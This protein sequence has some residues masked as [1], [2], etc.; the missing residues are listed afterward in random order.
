[1]NTTRRPR[2]IM[3]TCV[4]FCILFALC[5]AASGKV[6]YVDD[7]AVQANGGTS[8][9]DA[10]TSLQDALAGAAP[11]DEV[12]VAQGTYRPDQGA[13]ITPGDREAAF[14]IPT[15]VIVQGGYPGIHA[16]RGDRDSQLYPTILSGDLKGD[17]SPNP[18]VKTLADDPARKDNSLCV[19]VSQRNTTAT[20][21][22]GF[23]ITGAMRAGLSCVDSNPSISDCVFVYNLSPSEGGAVRLEGSDAV[24][25]QCTFIDNEAG[26]A[27]GAIYCD[28]TH[29]SM[30][31]CTFR[32]NSSKRGGAFVLAG[33][34]RSVMI[35]DCTFILNSADFGGAIHLYSS[36]MTLSGCLLKDNSARLS[37]GAIYDLAQWHTI[38]NCT[39]SSNQGQTGGAFFGLVRTVISNCVFEN[40]SG[41]S[42]SIGSWDCAGPDFVNCTMFGNHA[43]DGSSI[44]I[45]TC[46]IRMTPAV[47][48][49]SCIFWDSGDISATQ[50][51]KTPSWEV[52]YSLIQSGMAG[53]GNIDADPCFAAPGYW[54][55]NATPG[56]PNDDFW[57]DGDYHLKSQ[58]GRW[59]P[60]S[61]SWVQ[62]DVTSPCIDAGDPTALIGLEPFPNGGTIDMGIYGGTAQAS[63]SYFGQPLCNSIIAGDINGDCRVDMT[64]LEILMRHWLQDENPAS[65]PAPQK[66]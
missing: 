53:E 39:F 34:S 56:D 59:D 30:T 2:S 3:V 1:M 31:G 32:R 63:K 26:N 46:G 64:D 41:A 49:T 18:D 11:G 54:D 61:Q 23:T 29:L 16:H 66:R 44:A 8:W 7:S 47:S 10:F 45:G 37:G 52:T 35:G 58:A 13:G 20:V 14:A 50:A 27:G 25:T 9:A 19:V 33:P 60:A 55:P 4:L 12:W 62:D 21:L 57:V 40:N 5:A 24:L 48:M 43:D 38:R 65:T 22:D 17:D 51:S 28:G 6:I 15:G 42:G 36:H